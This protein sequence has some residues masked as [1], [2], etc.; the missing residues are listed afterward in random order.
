M[1]EDLLDQQILLLQRLSDL[2][3]R[4]ADEAYRQ[5]CSFTLEADHET[6][7]VKFLLDKSEHRLIATARKQRHR[8]RQR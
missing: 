5:K 6:Q 1:M 3:D 8:Q 2:T 4:V 7:Q